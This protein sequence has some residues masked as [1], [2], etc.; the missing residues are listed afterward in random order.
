MALADWTFVAGPTPVNTPDY[1]KTSVTGTNSV[2]GKVVTEGFRYDGSQADLERVV[3]SFVL[4]VSG[5]T[6][7]RPFVAPGT[8]LNI[9]PAA[10]TPPTAAELARQAWFNKLEL[11]EHRLRIK[12][13]G[14]VTGA[15]L[16]ALN[17]SIATLQAELH[18]DFLAAYGT[19]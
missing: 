6:A 17:D 5:A 3:R 19:P 1:V 15:K 11:L 10:A 9:I 12:N 8:T 7:L 16:T 14:A 2:T 18:S 4:A 13:A